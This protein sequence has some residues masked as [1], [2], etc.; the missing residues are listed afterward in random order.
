[1]TGV[2]ARWLKRAGQGLSRVSRDERAHPIAYSTSV[3]CPVR[4]S[5]VS[6]LLARR[7]T[8]TV[9]S[10]TVRAIG[11]HGVDEVNAVKLESVICDSAAPGQ[12]H[13]CFL[14]SAFS[15]SR[16]HG[17]L[18]QG[19]QDKSS[20]PPVPKR[21]RVPGWT[22]LETE[23]NHKARHQSGRCQDDHSTNRRSRGRHRW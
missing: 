22:A 7:T 21:S 3:S 9:P 4:L 23:N 8:F 5:V 10:R 12:A 17:N 20:D 16:N 1:M 2:W 6:P 11:A 14:A 18:V 19:G 15:R 13:S